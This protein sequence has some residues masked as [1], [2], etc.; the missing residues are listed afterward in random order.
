[1]MVSKITEQIL[2]DFLQKQPD[3]SG[4]FLQSAYWGQLMK[5]EGLLVELYGFYEADKLIGVC[6]IIYHKLPSGFRW[7]YAPKGPIALSGQSTKVINEL[8]KFLV[9]KKVVYLKIEPPINSSETDLLVEGFVRVKEIQTRQT[10]IM[11]LSKT[12]DELLSA[13]HQKTRYNIR[14]SEKKNLEWYWAEM[15]KFDD[16]W[17]I[18]KQTSEKDGFKLHSRRHYELL[19]NLF[20]QNKL[21]PDNLAVRLCSVSAEG[22]ILGSI[23]TVWYNNTVTYLHGGLL[24]IRR[25]L[26]ANYYLHWQTILKAKELG[27][28]KYDWWGI[29]LTGV[30]HQQSW[31][32][33]S[34]FK[35]GF[36]GETKLYL[37]AYDYVYNQPVYW[38]INII[39]FVRRMVNW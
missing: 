28:K 16:F 35:T 30:K 13:M 2:E 3:E 9:H 15:V 19:F 5:Q 20:G 26:M 11:N 36:G 25:E 37:G 1:M 39:K 14:L 18:L 29:A 32:G 7:V 8:K 22:Q 27:Y 24:N 23:M 4:W 33:F 21:K 17:N 12:T 34:R 38:L 6:Q 10:S 31:Y